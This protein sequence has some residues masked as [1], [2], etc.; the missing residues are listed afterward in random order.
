M[1]TAPPTP[2]TRTGF[3]PYGARPAGVPLSALQPGDRL[4]K[5]RRQRRPALAVAGGLLVVLCG[6]TSAALATAGNDRLRVLAL[7]RDVQAGQVLT[8]DDVLVAEL[9]GSGLSALSAD[10]ASL[11]VG[12]TVTAS[13]PAGTLLNDSMLS[14]TPLPGAGLQLVAVAVKPGGVPVEAAPGRD[15]T[16][17]KVVTTADPQAAAQPTVLV[18]R[19]RVV[20]VRTE[21][22]NGLVILSVQVPTSAALA[23][24]QASATGAVAVTLLP[25][26]P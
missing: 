23:V 8:A 7:A 19:A 25:V 3:V 16:L 1:T 14:R 13:L 10:G 2:Q 22:A 11:V 6:V 5:L 9:A 20:S 18:P 4:P 15:V 26:Q 12:Q 17:V 21:T 24:A